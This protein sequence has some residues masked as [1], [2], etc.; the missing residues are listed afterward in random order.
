MIIIPPF[1]EKETEKFAESHTATKK[2]ELKP[3]SGRWP[4]ESL[5]FAIML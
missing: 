1:A 2:L 4:S 5:L 3:E